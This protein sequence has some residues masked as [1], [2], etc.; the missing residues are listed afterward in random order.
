MTLFNQTA[1][2]RKS[3]NN[4][5]MAMHSIVSPFSGWRS[6]AECSLMSST[7][8]IWHSATLLAMQHLNSDD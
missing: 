8:Y 5:F 3:F 2:I 4:T 7:S 1:S 6:I